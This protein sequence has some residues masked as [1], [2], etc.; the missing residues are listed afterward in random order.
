MCSLSAANRDPAVY[1]APGEIEPDR[2]A[3]KH[4]A[5]GHGTH[6]CVGAELAR[7]ELRTAYPALVRRFP[8]MRLAVR[9]EELSFRGLSIVYGLHSLPVVLR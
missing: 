4:I 8:R 7:M 3:S 6:R 2:T 1:T 5:F 9:Q